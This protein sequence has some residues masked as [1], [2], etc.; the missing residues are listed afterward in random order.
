MKGGVFLA[1]DANNYDSVLM[2]DR[3]IQIINTLFQSDT[4]L[5]V[6]DISNYLDLPKATVYRI[7]NTLNKGNII[8]KNDNDKYSLGIVFIKYGEKVKSGLDLRTIASPFIKELSLITGEAVN[9]GIRNG[10]SV[11]TIDSAEGE[12]SVLI[13]KLIPIS[14]LHC[15]SMGKLFMS[16]MS[17]EKVKE[18]FSGKNIKRTINTI[19]NYNQFLI[20]KQKILYNNI[21]FDNEEYEYGLGCISSPIFDDNHIIVAAISVSGP[22]SRLNIKGISKIESNLLKTAQMITEKL[23]LAMIYV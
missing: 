8:E 16:Y 15:S 21:S 10:D 9:L 7:L 4:A 18:Y 1:I 19:T 13:S 23:S 12:S 20:E 6:S 5:G 14:P 2:V 3:T 17:D 22:L 11:L